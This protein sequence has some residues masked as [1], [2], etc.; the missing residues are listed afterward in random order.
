MSRREEFSWRMLFVA[1][2]LIVVGVLLMTQSAN[3]LFEMNPL[4]I[5]FIGL[6]AVFIFS[7]IILIVVAVAALASV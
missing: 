6:A 5:F 1:L 4:S 2:V 7:G 3:M